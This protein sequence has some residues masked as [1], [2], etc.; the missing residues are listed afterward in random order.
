MSR[1]LVKWLITVLFP[2]PC[3]SKTCLL[4]YNLATGSINN[5]LKIKIEAR[6]YSDAISKG[7]PICFDHM[8]N[9]S[10]LTETFKMDLIDACANPLFITDDDK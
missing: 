4:E 7:A 3:F 5:T 6:D 9:L 10:P 1:G 8:V 2:L